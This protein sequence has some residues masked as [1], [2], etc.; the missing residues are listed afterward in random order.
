MKRRSLLALLAAPPAL[1]ACSV[2]PERPYQARSIWP[3]RV[4]PPSGPPA[5]PGAPIL[6]VR[7]IAAAPGLEGS[8]LKILRPD[9]TLDSEFYQQWA[10][11]PAEAVAQALRDWLAGSGMFAAV[12]GTGSRLDADYV[13]EGQLTRLWAQ[14]ADHR[15]VA[16]LSLVLYAEQPLLARQVLGQW[17]ILGSAGLAGLAPAQNVAAQRAA[18]ADACAKAAALIRGQLAKPRAR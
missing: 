8:G 9:G 12:I 16:G 3:L 7:D 14:P 1:A 11:P 13:L 4:T 15:A 5:R 10:A 18:L 2:L 17:R 6:L